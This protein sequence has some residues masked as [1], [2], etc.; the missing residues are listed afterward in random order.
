M[1]KTAFQMHGEYLQIFILDDLTSTTIQILQDKIL[2][3]V[4]DKNPKGVLLDLSMLNIIDSYSATI[5]INILK[6]INV[7]GP[8]T[9]L[10]G[11]QAET[12]TYL[13]QKNI[14]FGDILIA[15]HLTEGME[16]LNNN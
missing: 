8:R 12:I 14:D 13:I 7:L 16:F 10:I 4:K 9:I 1:I 5:I 6:M 11:L 3:T 15:K 2:D